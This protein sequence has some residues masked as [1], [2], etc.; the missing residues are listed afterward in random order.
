VLRAGQLTRPSLYRPLDIRWLLPS[1]PAIFLAISFAKS[2]CHQ[3]LWWDNSYRQ[4]PPC[5]CQPPRPLAQPPRTQIA[6]CQGRIVHLPPI[7]IQRGPRQYQ[8]WHPVIIRAGSHWHNLDL[9][10]WRSLSN[11]CHGRLWRRV[12]I[13]RHRLWRL[14]IGG[15][16]LSR[17][18]LRPI[19]SLLSG[20][21]LRLVN[22]L[23]V[24]N[25]NI[26]HSSLHAACGDSDG[27]CEQ[28]DRCQCR[29]AFYI[30]SF[31]PVALDTDRHENIQTR[32]EADWKLS[33]PGS[34]ERFDVHALDTLAL[35]KGVTSHQTVS[36]TDE[37]PGVGL[38]EQQRCINSARNERCNV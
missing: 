16:R 6:P 9:W 37:T 2:P 18:W 20:L 31:H 25:R 21:L 34:P 1:R 5:Q 14:P 24:V 38:T 22:G 8:T 13:G 3:V 29:K 27:T 17:A 30:V 33:L 11:D 15:R 36:R 19:K 35:D 28:D 26:L 10:R 7:H 23:C 32:N 4:C 12:S